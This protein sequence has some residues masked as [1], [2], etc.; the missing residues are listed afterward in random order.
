MSEPV[1]YNVADRIATI[2]LNRPHRRNAWTGKMHFAYRA[3]LDDAERDSSVRAVIVTG[4]ASEDG[5]SAFCVG[6]D[7]EALEG[8]VE[9]GGYDSGLRRAPAMPGAGTDP[10]FEADFAYHFAMTKPVVAA[11]NGPAA[12]VGL[13]LVCFADTRFAVPGAKLTS[14]HGRIG[15]PAEYGLSWLLPRLVG[16]ARATELLFTSRAFL[17]DEAHEMGLVHRLVAP[18]ELMTETRRWVK[19]LIAN[20]AAESLAATKLQLYL[21]M[22]RDVRQSVEHAQE[23]LDELT[24]TEAYAHGIRALLNREPPNFHTRP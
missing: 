2:T 18:D 11:V 20:N 12:G 14:A 21:D 16:H 19:E 9:K 3:A 8:H 7:S 22:H 4:A 1:L 24:T 5:R 13:A 15:L 6:G 10:R 17:T 23:L